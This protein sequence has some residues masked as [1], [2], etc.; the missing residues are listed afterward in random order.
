MQITQ[1]KIHTIQVAL[2]LAGTLVVSAPTFATQQAQQR[3]EARDT[4]QDTRQ[5]A[6]G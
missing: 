4:R 6:R 5:R 3:R 1:T 2:I